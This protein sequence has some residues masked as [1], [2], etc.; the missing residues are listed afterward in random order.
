[1]AAWLTTA[2]LRTATAPLIRDRATN[3]VI[4]SLRKAQRRG[5]WQYT[6]L[7]RHNEQENSP[8]EKE[9]TLRTAHIRS[10]NKFVPSSWLRNRS[11]RT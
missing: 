7:L 2:H 8:V 10:C 11:H 4:F 1:M 6:T 9:E 3:M 5:S